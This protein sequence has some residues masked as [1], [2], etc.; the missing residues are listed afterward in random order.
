M[1]GL[2]PSPL[3]QW[4]QSALSFLYLQVLPTTLG[5]DHDSFLSLPLPLEPGS[6]Q[7]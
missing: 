4:D 2:V 5:P 3:D 1:K 7:I 6:L